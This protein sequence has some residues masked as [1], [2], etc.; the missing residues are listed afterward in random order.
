[1]GRGLKCRVLIKVRLVVRKEGPE[2]EEGQWDNGTRR[3]CQLK[4]K[5]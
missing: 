3:E 5:S 1:M 4:L 2:C